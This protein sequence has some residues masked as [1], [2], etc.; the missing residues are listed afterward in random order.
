VGKLNTDKDMKNLLPRK[1]FLRTIPCLFLIAFGF[2]ALA[3]E[4]T[5]TSKTEQVDQ[6]FANT[7]SSVA[8][9]ASVLV[10][11][12]G[13]IVHK[14]GYGLANLEKKVPNSPATIFRLGSVTKQFTAMAIL[15]L[16][17]KQKLNIDHPVGKY[18]SGTLNGD[19]MTIRHLLTH[20]SGIT[21][22]LDSELEFPPGERLNYSNIGYNLLGKIIEKVSG[23]SYENFLELNIFK[24]LGMDHTGY[25]HPGSEQ[26]NRASGYVI[27]TGGIYTDLSDTD[28]SNSY[29][30]GALYST[31]EDMYLWDQA[32]NSERLI[33]TGTLNQAFSQVSLNNGSK[34]SYGFGWMVNPWRGLREVGHG[35][36]ITGFNSHIARFPD[37]QFSVIVLSNV[38]MRPPGP[39]A[40][41]GDLA[42]KIAEIYLSD[43]LTAGPEHVAIQL[44]AEM[45]EEYVGQYR[46]LNAPQEIL[47]VTGE[48]FT[49]RRAGQQLFFQGKVGETE[50]L[51]N[52][53]DHFF[54]SDNTTIKFTRVN[55]KVTGFVFDLMGLGVR[56]LTAERIDP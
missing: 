19:L 35:G 30:A 9:G 40:N 46:L 34:A 8:P 44:N 51:A 16:H 39:L 15:Q 13:E 21:Q 37:E 27:G 42:H 24:P 6:L 32:L 17:D 23:L 56:V 5:Q 22:S 45:L 3:Q 10:V 48:T 2:P 38:Q 55:G 12:E 1:G 25:E 26:E 53:E 20:T 43:K 29:A 18:I 33:S 14:K 54:I 11:H 4:G 52:A 36:D 28:V 50:V 7:E 49:V 41:A 31:V 47:A